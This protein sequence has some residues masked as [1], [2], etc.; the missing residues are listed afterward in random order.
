MLGDGSWSADGSGYSVWMDGEERK[1]QRA[2]EEIS[3]L[4]FG[5]FVFQRFDDCLTVKVGSYSDLSSRSFKKTIVM[6]INTFATELY[7]KK[8]KRRQMKFLHVVN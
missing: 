4:G 1:R 7:K 6:T 3:A 5:F 2:E 8:K